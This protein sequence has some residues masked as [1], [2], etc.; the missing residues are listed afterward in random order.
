MDL[1]DPEIYQFRVGDIGKGIPQRVSVFSVL[2]FLF[3]FL[4]IRDSASKKAPAS[5]TA[6]A[7][8]LKPYLYQRLQLELLLKLTC[9]E[10]DSHNL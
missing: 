9:S 3:L 10:L 7:F 4:Q 1:Y 2:L 6:A 5:K 8:A